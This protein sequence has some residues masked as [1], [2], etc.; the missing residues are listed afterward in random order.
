M[1]SEWWEDENF[2]NVKWH[3]VCLRKTPYATPEL[4]TELMQQRQPYEEHELN[5]Y[6]CPFCLWWHMGRKLDD[7]SQWYMT[8]V[9]RLLQQGHWNGNY[10]RHPAGL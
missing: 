10:I 6:E 8:K 2:L 7:N 9:R 3:F 1:H 4:A 5:V